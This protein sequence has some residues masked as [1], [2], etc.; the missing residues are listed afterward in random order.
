[1][2]RT[3]WDLDNCVN[4]VKGVKTGGYKYSAAATPCP[5]YLVVQ[6]SSRI[7]EHTLMPGCMHSGR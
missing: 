3:L 5:L 6:I 7:P 4:T 1:M 2:N